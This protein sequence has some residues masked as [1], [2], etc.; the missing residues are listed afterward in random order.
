MAM[1]RALSGARALS[2]AA[3]LILVS[4]ALTDAPVAQPS[5]EDL[6]ALNQQIGQLH[7]S[8]K[9]AE[10]TALAEQYQIR[11]VVNQAARKS[12]DH[13]TGNRYM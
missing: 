5:A 12:P 7:E 1:L 4:L 2:A 13:L 11:R 3:V 8:S 10:A 6:A 9:Y